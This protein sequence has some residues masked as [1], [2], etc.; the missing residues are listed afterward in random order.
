MGGLFLA[1]GSLIGGSAAGGGRPAR[2][3]G[4]RH[5]RR[6]GLIL[7]ALVV[8]VAAAAPWL[9][10]NPPER[11]FD[12]HLYAP[13]TRVHLFQGG[14]RAPFIYPSE[15]REPARAP[16]RGRP[17]PPGAAPM[18]HRRPAGFRGRGQRPAA[19]PWCG[20]LRSR[21]LCP[22]ALRR[23]RHARA[24]GHCHRGGDSD[25]R[26]RR[27]CLRVRGR[28]DRR[29]ALAHV[30]LR[31]RAARDL[32]RARATGGDAARPP[33]QH[34]LHAARRDLCAAWLAD[35]RP[36]CAC[37]R[38]VGARR[39]TTRSPAMRSAPG[40]RACCCATCCLRR[41]ATSSVQAT[42]LLPAFILAEATL[43]YVG[44]GFPDTVPT[45]GT[46]L[47]DAA[48]VALLVEAPWMLAPAA[49]IF[50]VVLAVNLAVQGAD[51]RLYNWSHE[52]AS[53]G[54]SR[55]SSRRSSATTPLTNGRC[56]ATWRAGC[57]RR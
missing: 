51:G 33:G 8:L 34:G 1:F 7:L 21:H 17:N 24:R 42:L 52:A 22:P 12:G 44:L 54:S 57:A 2:A 37:D 56:A 20:R 16:V 9:A 4:G 19:A 6:A 43:S 29:G 39:A 49:A 45:W 38:R 41:A 46:M 13:P 47:Q 25:R 11:R 30:G 18:V 26:A 23:A 50:V 40:R 10:P 32:R 53:P 5:V 15:A 48:N 35:R 14:P 27:R 55:R 31:A 28:R 36:R 3:R